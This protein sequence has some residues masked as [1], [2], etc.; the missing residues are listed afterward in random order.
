LRAVKSIPSEKMIQDLTLM[1][2]N[3]ISRM[4]RIVRITR[5]LRFSVSVGV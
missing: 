2:I 1:S 3:R 4:D 5:I